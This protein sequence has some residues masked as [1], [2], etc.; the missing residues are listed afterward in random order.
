MKEDEYFDAAGFEAASIKGFGTQW[1]PHRNDAAWPAYRF[2]KNVC[3]PDSDELFISCRD[4]R[5]LE[6]VELLERDWQTSRHLQ[7]KPL[8]GMPS[9]KL[10]IRESLEGFGRLMT[11]L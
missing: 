2:A 9:E 8:Y 6:V 3:A 11:L 4:F 5:A 7:I 1:I 10:K